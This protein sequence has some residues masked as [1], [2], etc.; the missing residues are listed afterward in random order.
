MPH[1]KT[2]IISALVTIGVMAVVFRV[3]QLKSAVT[4]A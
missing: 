2:L 3:P 4:G 1:V